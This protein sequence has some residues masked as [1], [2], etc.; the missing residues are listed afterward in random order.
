MPCCLGIIALSVPRFVILLIVIFSDYIG[1]AYETTL[2]PF[3]GFLFMPTTTLRAMYL[4]LPP[5]SLLSR[6]GR[7]KL[8][9]FR[10]SSY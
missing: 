3:L 6:F 10:G 7:D 8:R 2:L 5:I 1:T 4:G 9:L